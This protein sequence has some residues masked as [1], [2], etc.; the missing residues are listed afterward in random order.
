MFAL[1]CRSA[2]IWMDTAIRRWDSVIDEETGRLRG[3]W[4]I[5]EY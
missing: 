1:I 5:R 4:G 3:V 2:V